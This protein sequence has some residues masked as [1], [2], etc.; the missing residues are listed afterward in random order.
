MNLELNKAEFKSIMKELMNDP[1]HKDNIVLKTFVTSS[2][3]A[4]T[5]K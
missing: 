4:A 2:I 3:E 1:E 5:K